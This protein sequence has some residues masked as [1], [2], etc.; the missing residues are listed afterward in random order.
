MSGRKHI[1]GA[2]ILEFLLAVGVVA[3]VTPVAIRFANRE[4]QETR[5]IGIAKQLRLVGESMLNYAAREKRN[6]GKAPRDEMKGAAQRMVADYGLAPEVPEEMVRGMRVIHRQAKGGYFEVFATADLG[7]YDL[8]DIEFRQTLSLV[9]D[10]A[11]FIEGGEIY[12]ITGAWE[13]DA[14]R[15]GLMRA[16]PRV[17]VLRITDADLDA[18]YGSSEYLYRNSFGGDDGSRMSVALS[19]DGHNI[20]AFRGLWAKSVAARELVFKNLI[21]EAELKVEGNMILSGM[22]T[23]LEGAKIFAPEFELRGRSFLKELS[24]TDAAVSGAEGAASAELNVMG[25]AVA[26]DMAAKTLVA[27][28]L[29]GGA[30]VKIAG[31]GLKAYIRSFKTGLLEAGAIAIGNGRLSGRGV[32]ADYGFLVLDEGADF[33]I[34]NVRT[35]KKPSSPAAGD[36]PLER[37]LDPRRLAQRMQALNRALYYRIEQLQL[38]KESARW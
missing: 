2:S 30:P 27:G 11:G 28:K 37:G 20:R 31:E 5:R 6:W 29:S 35:T 13:D 10:Y 3:L 22:L 17:A 34:Y 7:H 38:E 36:M 15:L 21:S 25:D 32:Q 26:D 18:D 1:A 9:G 19:L 16:G 8:S 12:S 23:F 4:I 33:R 24:A 14:K